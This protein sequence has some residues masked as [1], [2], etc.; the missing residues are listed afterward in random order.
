MSPE[1]WAKAVQYSC[2]MAFSVT[3]RVWDVKDIAALV[4]ALD[5]SQ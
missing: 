5:G 3:D 1:I 2:V 4:V